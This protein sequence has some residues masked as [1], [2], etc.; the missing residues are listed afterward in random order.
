MII[1]SP[2]NEH[3]ANLL[4]SFLFHGAMAMKLLRVIAAAVILAAS[5]SLAVT[6]QQVRADTYT[7]QP[8]GTAGLDTLMQSDN[9][10]TNFGTNTILNIGEHNAAT[11][12]NRSLLKFDLSSIPNNAIINSA[13]LSLWQSAED[14][15]NAETLRVYRSLRAWVESQATWNVFSTGNNWGSAGGYGGADSDTA[16][17]ASREFSATEAN[18]EKQFVFEASGL[19]ALQSFVNGSATN[20]G[21]LLKA[22]NE[23]NDLYHF[24]SSDWTTAAERPKLVI[25]YTVPTDTP[26]P[27]ATDTPTDTPTATDTPT[28]TPT[29][30]ATDTPTDTPTATN[31]PTDT[32]TPTA[33]FTPSNTPTPGVY[34]YLLSSGQTFIIEPE[35]RFGEI[36][37]GGMLVAWLLVFLVY[38]IYRV[39]EKWA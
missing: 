16:Q 35:I 8:D 32:A 29:P 27:T 26:T 2:A 9:P 5:L 19:A 20:N 4:A 12:T 6:P 10:T 15:N 11:S 30:T 24:R 33:T 22:D 23:L 28:D 3:L 31:T 34:T 17:L 1:H 25:D 21:F 18:G 37:Q 14:S 13:T 38:V 7:S 36:V 39:I